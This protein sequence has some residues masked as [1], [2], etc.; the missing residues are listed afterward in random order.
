M[1][2]DAFQKLVDEK[3]EQYRTELDNQKRKKNND[4][5]G[6]NEKY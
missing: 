4:K 3:I 5:S 1:K 6:Y 2:S